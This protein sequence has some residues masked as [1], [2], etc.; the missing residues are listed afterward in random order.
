MNK[1]QVLVQS[2]IT[3]LIQA[4]F[5]ADAKAAELAELYRDHPVLRNMRVPTLNISNVSV[6]LR[7]AFDDAPLAAPEE[8]SKAQ[9]EA[10]AAAAKALNARLVSL[11]SV[12][13]KFTAAKQRSLTQK[14]KKAAKAEAANAEGLRGT[15]LNT[16][17]EAM[18]K[19]SK[20]KLKASERSVLDTEMS[21][22][23][24]SIAAAPKLMGSVPGVV[25]EAAALEKLPPDSITSI[26][27][28]IS[29][30]DASWTS[31]ADVDQSDLLTND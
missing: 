25:V 17:V 9:E 4:R 19:E 8:A 10:I 16:Q 15:F 27:F 31:I 6:D 26:K 3:D 7:V 14:I 29:L 11:E 23:E 12:K 18:L 5:E 2:I 22:L 28:E 1:L 30:G 20:I 21:V 13:P 24:A